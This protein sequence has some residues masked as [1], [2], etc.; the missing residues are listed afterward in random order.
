MTI[1]KRTDAARELYDKIN[2]IKINVDELKPREAKALA[3]VSEYHHII[4]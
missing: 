4:D 2:T 3:Q 1:K